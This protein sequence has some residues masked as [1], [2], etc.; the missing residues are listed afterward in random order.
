MAPTPEHLS[1]RWRSVLSRCER[2]AHH[3][4]DDHEPLLELLAAGL[5]TTRRDSNGQ[6]IYRLTWLGVEA[7]EQGWW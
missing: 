7:L 3:E 4:P 2:P 6:I 1:P 5:V